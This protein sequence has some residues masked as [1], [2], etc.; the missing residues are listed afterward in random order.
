MLHSYP[1]VRGSPWSHKLTQ[2]LSSNHSRA[3]KFKNSPNAVLDYQGHTTS[4]P[5]RGIRVGGG[6]T[7]RVV[8]QSFKL[9][10]Q[11][12][13][14][15]ASIWQRH[16]VQIKGSP[17]PL[18]VVSLFSLTFNVNAR[19]QQRSCRRQFLSQPPRVPTLRTGSGVF[20]LR[21][22]LSKRPLFLSPPN[23]WQLHIFIR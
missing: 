7:R 23:D 8:Q 12:I 3:F 6:N 18:S 1:C 5:N 19:D 16:Q 14:R 21:R 17:G 2:G 10:R 20:L 13:I 11:S 22:L 4:Q 9:A 15:S